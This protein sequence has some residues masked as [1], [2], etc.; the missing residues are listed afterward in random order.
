[1]KQ[2]IFGI[3]PSVA[4]ADGPTDQTWRIL[5][6]LQDA[7]AGNGNTNKLTMPIAGTFSNLHLLCFTPVGGG[8]TV[9]WALEKNNV[10]TSLAV[11][12]T[13]AVQTDYQNTTDLVHV[14]VGDTVQWHPRLSAGSTSLLGTRISLCVE[15]DSDVP[16][17]CFYARGARTAINNR[18]SPIFHQ[19]GRETYTNPEDAK[20]L[21]GVPGNITSLFAATLIAAGAGGTPLAPGAGKWFEVALYKNHVRQ[22]GTAGTVDTVCR[23]AD[24]NVDATKT[25]T[26]PVVAGDLIYIR[27]TNSG[28]LNAFLNWRGSIK[29]VSA[30]DNDFSIVS[31][32]DPPTS[33]VTS[34]YFPPNTEGDWVTSTT[35]SENEMVGPITPLTIGGMIGDLE[36]APGDPSESIQYH[37][38][39]NGADTGVFLDFVGSQTTDQ[40]GGAV[41][42]TSADLWSIRKIGFGATPSSGGGQVITFPGVSGVVP[43]S[44]GAI[45]VEKVAPAD[46]DQVFPFVT[47]NLTPTNFDLMHGQSQSFPGL[48]PDDGYSV[49]ETVPDGWTV[50]YD[51]SNGSPHTNISVDA[52]ETVVVTVTN[53]LICPG[54]LGP[55]LIDGAPYA[56]F[57]GDPC[58]DGTGTVGGPLIDGAP[59]RPFTG[60]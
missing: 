39:V 42:L 33:T 12:L 6:G 24:L 51:V 55:A 30:T 57:S 58:P 22:D 3:H 7:L 18:Y 20:D 19:Q 11:T 41:V 1:V 8:V 49:V 47:V 10:D 16:N 54:L 28:G 36:T 26:L 4:I 35:E 46:L 32:N 59:Y 17:E 5:L 53:A 52:G 44:E 40:V 23:V 2:F 31:V 29:F 60:S 38:R 56:P 9:P 27:E 48:T 34:R 14:N 43:P 15:F 21:M 50:S 45:I 13:G 25:F 37:L